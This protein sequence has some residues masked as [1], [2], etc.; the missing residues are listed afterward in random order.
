MKQHITPARALLSCLGLTVVSAVSVAAE[1]PVVDASG[2]PIVPAVAAPQTPAPAVANAP[3]VGAENGVPESELNPN[4]PDEYVVRKGDTLWAISGRFLRS[5]WKW[6][7]L[8]RMNK[9]QI[10]NP[11]LI[12]PGQRLHLIRADGRAWLSG[13]GGN[14]LETFRMSPQTRVEML[15]SGPIATIKSHLIEPFLAEP[16]VV[17]D[18]TFE[19][20]PR[21]VSSD[22]AGRIMMGKGDR[23]YARGPVDSPLML[24]DGVTNQRYRV[25]RNAVPLKDPLSGEILGYEGQY[26]GLVDL[27]RGESIVDTPKSEGSEKSWLGFKSKGEEETLTLAVPATVD[28]ISTKEEIRIGDRLLPEPKRQFLSYTPHAPEM[29]MEAR[30]VSIY[31]D[32]VT[33]AGQNQVV[34]INKG[35][36]DGIENGHVLVMMSTGQQVVDRTESRRGELIKLPDE[37]NGL[38]LVFRPFEHVSYALLMESTHPVKVGDKLVSPPK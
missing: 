16:L 11:H 12:Y 9:A 15:D 17:D 36:A 7:Q 6:P 29:P 25:F 14:V 38:A 20:A 4:A 24:T 27:I 26:V 1:Y 33:F 5:P 13:K 32:A 34:A 35:L 19:T 28:I 37:R 3:Q 31:G 22:A 18:D 10:R 21:I 8:W 2:L 30:V 23:A